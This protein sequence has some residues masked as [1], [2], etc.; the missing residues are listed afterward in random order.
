M[1]K[2]RSST[3]TETIKKKKANPETLEMKNAMSRLKSIK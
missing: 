3:K 2:M 1:N